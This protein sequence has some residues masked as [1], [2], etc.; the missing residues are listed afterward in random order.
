M[1]RLSTGI[2]DQFYLSGLGISISR[3]EDRL[4]ILPLPI[5]GED[6]LIKSKRSGLSAQKIL[7]L[8][9]ELLGITNNR[10]SP[11]TTLCMLPTSIS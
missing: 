8:D 1:F 11:E 6:S 9:G 7:R 5:S 2:N 10:T 4:H 3:L